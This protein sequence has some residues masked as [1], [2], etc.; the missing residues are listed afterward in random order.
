VR[1][2]DSNST[3]K[4]HQGVRALVKRMCHCWHK[5]KSNERIFVHWVFST[6]KMF[7]LQETN[8]ERII[9]KNVETETS[10]CNA[11]YYLNL[12]FSFQNLCLIFSLNCCV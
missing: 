8:Y 5:R 7:K 9:E 1:A 12:L 10:S 6:L 11:D 3:Q 4:P 2:A